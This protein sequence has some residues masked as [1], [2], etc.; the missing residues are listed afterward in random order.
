MKGGK[1]G[2]E[3]DIYAEKRTDF[4]SSDSATTC[5]TART[6]RRVVLFRK[7]KPYISPG[8]HTNKSETD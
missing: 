3:S 4:D 2:K 1:E 5:N 6:R 7:W 8:V